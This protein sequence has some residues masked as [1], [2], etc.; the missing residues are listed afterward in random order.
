MKKNQNTTRKAPIF[1]VHFILSIARIIIT[2]I[3]KF[4]SSHFELK[5]KKKTLSL[6]KRNK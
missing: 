3:F 4:I 2:S 5:L 6:L 1:I